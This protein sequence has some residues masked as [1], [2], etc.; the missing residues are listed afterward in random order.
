MMNRVKFFVFPL[1]VLLLLMSAQ[2][3]QA[4]VDRVN[5][6]PDG[7]VRP[8]VLLPV[9]GNGFNVTDGETYTWSFSANP[10]VT[11]T[12]D[13]SLTDTLTCV[14]AA[15]SCDFRYIVEDNEPPEA[16]AT[17]QAMVECGVEDITLDGSGSS[18][19]DDGIE[20]YSWTG[21]AGVTITN[22]D[23]AIATVDAGELAPG[24]H[25]FTL[26]VTDFFGDSDSASV[27][28]IVKDT[29]APVIATR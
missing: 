26:T 5:A 25:T 23:Q 11:V 24:T 22:A 17:A 4:Q 14:P 7:Q 21:P 20:T 28:V 2:V 10:D 16:V 27:D 1:A 12:H 19:S 9:F 8:G 18:D 6:M 15:A 13:G 29:T 3:G